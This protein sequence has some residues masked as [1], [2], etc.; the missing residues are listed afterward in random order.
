M[1]EKKVRPDL[2]D[3]SGRGATSCALLLAVFLFPNASVFAGEFRV[4]P[5]QSVFAVVTHKGGLAG[6]LAHD[7][8]IAASEYSARLD[9]TDSDRLATQFHVHLAAENLVVDS[10]SL[11]ERWYSRL[12]AL[13][14]V[15][16]PFGSLS[17]KDRA[18]I[19]ETMLGVKQLDAV[20]FPEISARVLSI[21]EETKD[22]GE[23]QLSHRVMLALS[24][25]GQTV[26]KPVWAR[27]ELVDGA[28]R[29][30]AV[31]E[32]RF[33]DFGIKPYSAMLGAVKNKDSF[34]LYV[35]LVAAP[36]ND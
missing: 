18:K 29:V 4:I 28:L 2:R 8:F 33:R 27:Y 15:N 19:R 13:G 22:Q 35:N 20:A 26:E 16:K 7:H 30:E 12:E 6:G 36:I 10:E 25:H 24:V 5:E 34:H 11:H 3:G 32:F 23:V 1:K 17:D 21:D 9:F 31:G 14:L